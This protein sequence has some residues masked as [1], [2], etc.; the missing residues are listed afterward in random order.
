MKHQDRD[1]SI[2]QLLRAMPDD[3][4]A[5]VQPACLDVETLAAWAEGALQ[6]GARA[7]AESHAASC[8]RCQALLAAMART[9]D[10][11]AAAAPPRT[12][13][14][15]A[16]PWLGPIGAAAMAAALVLAILPRVGNESPPVSPIADAAVEKAEKEVARDAPAPAPAT[17]STPRAR[18]EGQAA[19]PQR[20]VLDKVEPRQQ[21]AP[22]P[23]LKSRTA[24]STPPLPV[25]ELP[26]PAAPRPA[27]PP[28]AASSARAAPPLPDAPTELRREVGQV[29][30]GRDARLK[31]A[32]AEIAAPPPVLIS[33]PEPRIRW[34]ILNGNVLQQSVDS[35][36]TWVSRMVPDARFVAGSAPSPDVC[37][38]VG[39][40][41]LI[42]VTTDGAAWLRVPFPEAIDLV[43]VA[44]TSADAATVTAADGRVFSTTD[45]GRTWSRR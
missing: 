11:G 40:R 42:M 45:R 26:P 4:R 44:A 10:A 18:A 39:Q 33:T 30:A 9:V 6:G 27:A 16:A 1:Q 20:K 19:L 29:A 41:G 38:V 3:G 12:W 14:V 43:I 15:R 13:L 32:V 31:E 23:L 35:G 37:W 8:A 22:I 24:S 25:P 5:E 21:E 17:S 28:P 7:H 34:R 36:A 2:D